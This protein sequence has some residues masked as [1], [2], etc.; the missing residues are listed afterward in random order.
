MKMSMIG[1][2]LASCALVG[3]EVAAAQSE[4]TGPS[5]GVVREAGSLKVE[6]AFERA[7]VRVYVLGA[8]QRPLDVKRVSGVVELTF[9]DGDRAPETVEL[10]AQRVRGPMCLLGRADLAGVL[11]GRAT[12]S[13]RL[14]QVP[15][16]GDV[17]V[18]VPFRLARVIEHVC[19]MSCVPAQ[20][21]P[22]KCARCKM[23]LVAAPY[24]W[25]CTEHPRVTSRE[26]G[27][28]SAEGCGKALAKRAEP[29]PRGQGQGGHGG[30]GGH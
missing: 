16:V 18:E 22:G 20:E 9:Q 27:S 24:I 23:D 10:K 19:P 6:V 13:V 21:A 14:T 2:A 12:A 11:E 25:A 7:G 17:A 15:D 26:P 29:R 3:V 5:G 1:F 8:D 4:V 30:H 28:C